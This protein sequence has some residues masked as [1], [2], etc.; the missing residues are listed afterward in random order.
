MT[1]WG[2][3]VRAAKTLLGSYLQLPHGKV[4]TVERFCILL[5]IGTFHEEEVLRA[6]QLFMQDC[7]TLQR[8]T[9]PRAPPWVHGAI[10]AVHQLHE[11]ATPFAPLDPMLLQIAHQHRATLHPLVQILRARWDA[12][13]HA[14]T[15]THCHK[16]G[17]WNCEGLP[18]AGSDPKHP[19]S[20]SQRK[21]Q[22]TLRAVRRHPV[23][24]QETGWEHVDIAVLKD[25]YPLGWH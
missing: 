15:A 24:L 1:L 20:P 5:N 25:Q 3:S 16:V 17:T 23:A 21:L 2:L 19:V 13:K 6:G 4:P 12:Y 7:T 8:W 18:L 9:H 10:V 22:A 11:P 14:R